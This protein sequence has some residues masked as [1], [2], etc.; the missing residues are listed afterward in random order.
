MRALKLVPNSI[1]LAVL[2]IGCG[3]SDE[4]DD[5]VQFESV[6]S[7]GDSLSDVGTYEVGTIAELDG[8]QFTVNGAAPR[9]WT[10]FLSDALNTPAQCAARTGMLPNDGTTG[11]PV[12]DFPECDN[13]AQGSARVTFSGTG[14]NGVGL[15]E[16]GLINLGF[17]AD[18][19]RNQIDRHLLK[20]GG[21]YSGRELITVNAGANDLFVQLQAIVLAGAGGVDALRRSAGCRL[22]ARGDRHRLRWRR[23]GHCRCDRGSDRRDGPSGVRVG[24]VHRDLHDQQRRSLRVGP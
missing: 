21:T 8:G 13:Y 11:A 23:G 15:Q 2:V 17:L 16:L 9:V 5:T 6:V 22:V 24:R 7:F 12:T 1:V 14:P 10:E 18:S 3:G 4:T 19:L 20:I